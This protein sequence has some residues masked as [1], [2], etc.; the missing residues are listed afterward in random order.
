MPVAARAHHRAR[1]QCG[2]PMGTPLQWGPVVSRPTAAA[3][4]PGASHSTTR[5][6][7]EALVPQRAVNLHPIAG[8][9]AVTLILLLITV[10]AITLIVLRVVLLILTFLFL[11]QRVEL[12]FTWSRSRGAHCQATPPGH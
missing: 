3:P 5:P 1:R 4:A 8:L 10:I 9:P 7:P 12:I 2:S 6:A 11:V